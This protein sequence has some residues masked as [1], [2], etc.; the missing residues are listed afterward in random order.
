MSL[1]AYQNHGGVMT[2]DTAC[3]REQN[4]RLPERSA[5]GPRSRDRS[6]LGNR[7]TWLGND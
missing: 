3:N 7:P 2:L 4:H 1:S 6:R 5:D